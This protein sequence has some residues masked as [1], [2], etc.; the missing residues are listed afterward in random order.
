[1]STMW[2]PHTFNLESG[3]CQFLGEHVCLLD[4]TK[5]GPK[6]VR[7]WVVRWRRCY[8]DCNMKSWGCASPYV[9][10]CATRPLRSTLPR[11][12]FKLLHAVYPL[13]SSHRGCRR[14]STCSR[15]LET[16]LAVCAFV[17]LLFFCSEVQ[18]WLKETQCDYKMI[19]NASRF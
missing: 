5:K 10:Y 4:P 6:E 12:D 8:C 17:N 11:R 15:T 1:M 18:F 3:Y 9:L 2:H 13:I 16:G 14:D 19:P 7:R